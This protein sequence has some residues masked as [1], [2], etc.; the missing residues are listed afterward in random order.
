MKRVAAYYIIFLEVVLVFV[1]G[2][3]SL[4]GRL[5]FDCGWL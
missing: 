4:C 1:F 3:F 2:V 5:H